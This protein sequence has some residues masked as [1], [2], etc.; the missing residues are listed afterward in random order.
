MNREKINK[1]N[2]YL[3]VAFLML[4]PILELLLAVFKDNSFS[5]AGISVATL[6]RYGLFAV[7]MFMT[8][9]PNL[10]RKS[11]K[12]F[13]CA[14]VVYVLYFAIHYINIRNFNLVIM[15]DNM[16]KGVFA[17]AI[18]ISKFIIPISIVYF[19]YV[20]NFGYREIKNCVLFTSIFVSLVLIITNLCGID[21]M[22]YSFEENEPVAANVIKWFDP[23]YKYDEWRMLT[24][25]G[26][27]P[28]GN[29]LSSLFAVLLPVVIWIAFKEK[30]NYYFGFAIIQMIAMLLIGTRI[31]VY[32][33]IG[34]L[35]LVS[36]IWLVDKIIKGEKNGKGKIIGIAT[37]TL[38]YLVFFLNSPFFHRI[39]VGEGIDNSYSKEEKKETETELTE[40]D[41]TEDRIYIKT[42]Y[43]KAMIPKDMIVEKY[44]YLEHSEFWIYV[45]DNVDIS[46]RNNARKLK[47]LILDDIKTNK[48]SR[49]DSLVGFGEIP[50]YPERDYIAQSYYIGVVG[51]IIFLLPFIL[52]AIVS[53][54]YNLI[55]F[56]GK[57]LDG[58]QVVSLL[59]LFIFFGTG[60]LAGHAIEPIYIN[61]FIG[62]L[63]GFL[64]M[65]LIN[66]S[67]DAVSE[68]GLEKYINRVYKDGREKFVE[69]LEKNV[70][71]N[72][73]KFIVTANPETLM[74]ARGNAEFDKCLM[75]G[76]TTIVPDGIGVIK[77]AQILRYD[78]KETITGVEL[79]KKLFEI[80]NE[81]SKSI[82]LFG[83]K[84]EVV[85]K[86][87]EVIEKDYPK[88]EIKGIQ[89]GY[90]SD[91]QNTFEEIKKLKPD[92]VLVALGIPHQELLIY[93]NLKEFE[94]GIFM[95]VGGSFDVL[96]GDKK[97]APNIF[98]KTHTEWLYRITVEPKRLKRFFNSNIKYIFKII[99]E[100]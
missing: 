17:A 70:V 75:D 67:T 20:L 21:Y 76:D 16:Q 62:L 54:I 26:V 10:K 53:L 94:H 31:S 48:N 81:H 34:V 74:I 13:I 92:I 64:V 86:L 35:I 39:L 7:I 3:L 37:I 22:A 66:R 57:R 25:R 2:K 82:Y 88:I 89:N 6:I 23:N 52:L 18:Y 68:K 50:I 56:F 9:I 44:N 8:V 90:V 49:L 1:I 77:G 96:S 69:E 51:V 78:I 65:K 29:E 85:L 27:Y 79:C 93:N 15:G 4:Q 71:N 97:R 72:D 11:T 98:V 24:S 47:T 43:F 95:G 5:I 83:A 87:K 100:K 32:G 33:E 41:N 30:R 14:L 55:R 63:S 45:I 61:S 73:K 42:H 84:E 36:I 12:I 58:D 40:D 28:S 91:K 38:V 99:Q 59:S 46:Q 19:V 80:A 60:Y